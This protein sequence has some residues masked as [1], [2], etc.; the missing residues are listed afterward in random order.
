MLMKW[1]NDENGC[2]L[3]DDQNLRLVNGIQIEFPRANGFLF[4]MYIKWSD[5]QASIDLQWKRNLRESIE[6]MGDWSMKT[7]LNLCSCPISVRHSKIIC[8]HAF[9]M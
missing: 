9:V 8:F 2:R 4:I 6:M 3:L 1:S 5:Y 7:C